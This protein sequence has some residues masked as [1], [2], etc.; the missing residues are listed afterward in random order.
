MQNDVCTYYNFLKNP[1]NVFQRSGLNTNF[2]VASPVTAKHKRK[3]AA[4]KFLQTLMSSTK[5]LIGLCCHILS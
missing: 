3:F 4:K 2:V 5:L 1:Q